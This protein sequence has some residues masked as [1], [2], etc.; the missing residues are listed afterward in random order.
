MCTL[1]FLH[2][3]NS[4]SLYSKLTVHEFVNWNTIFYSISLSLSLSL[5]VFLTLRN[6]LLS[7]LY[8]YGCRLGWVFGSV[9]WIGLWTSLEIGKVTTAIAMM[10]CRLADVCIRI[11][12]H[13]FSDSMHWSTTSISSYNDDNWSLGL[14]VVFLQWQWSEFE[15]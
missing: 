2:S 8:G 7:A 3:M 15:V 1:I 14:R 4:K 10:I 5:S 9:I 11:L 13:C 12:K 6:S